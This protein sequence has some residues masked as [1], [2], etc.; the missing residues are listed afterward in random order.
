MHI[1]FNVT[2]LRIPMRREHPICFS[3][4]IGG[5]IGLL[6]ALVLELSGP[7]SSPSTVTL[8]L[9]LWP[10]S[11]VGIAWLEPTGFNATTISMVLVMYGGNAFIYAVVASILTG[12]VLEIRGL[13]N[14]KDRRPQSIKPD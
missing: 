13:F 2:I 3:A 7:Y 9:I 14:K 6:V 5:M 10:T 4:I 1:V 12:L 11:I 8:I